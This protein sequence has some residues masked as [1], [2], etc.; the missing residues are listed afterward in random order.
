MIAQ[1]PYIHHR[2]C[3]EHRN[4]RCVDVH[5]SLKNI[6]HNESRMNPQISQARKR[7]QNSFECNQTLLLVTLLQQKK[8]L[9]ETSVAG[10][11]SC[12]RCNRCKERGASGAKRDRAAHIHAQKHADKGAAARATQMTNKEISFE[13]GIENGRKRSIS[14]A[15]IPIFGK[16][17]G[18]IWPCLLYTSPSPRD[19]STSRMPSSA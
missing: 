5:E 16:Y 4:G 11:S 10:A 13:L 1:S 14:E 15:F 17:F 18:G 8:L 12:R 19:L 6:A 3:Q 9:Q 2:I 7:D